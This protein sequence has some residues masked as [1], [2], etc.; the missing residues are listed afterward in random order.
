M[1]IRETLPAGALSVAGL[2]LLAGLMLAP[3]PDAPL[4]G[5][6]FPPW[7]DGGTALAHAAALALPI[8][9]IR[10]HGRLVV[11]APPASDPVGWRAGLPA[12]SLVIAASALLCT[13]PALATPQPGPDR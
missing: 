2:A 5:V 12:G 8:V 3:Q 10:W 1:Q 11:L 6:V 13:L 9:D 4:V 7:I